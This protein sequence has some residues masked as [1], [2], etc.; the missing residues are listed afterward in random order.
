M[1]EASAAKAAGDSKRQKELGRSIRETKAKMADLVKKGGFDAALIT[2]EHAISAVSVTET[3]AVAP[4]A[5]G[6]DV[7]SD[8]VS[9]S[10]KIHDEFN[11]Q[12][13]PKLSCSSTGGP[14][15]DEDG[16]EVDI[17]DYNNDGSES[18]GDKA[19]SEC[20]VSDLDDCEYSTHD[21]PHN[22]TSKGWTGLSPRDLLAEVVRRKF[23]Y[24]TTS[25]FLRTPNRCALSGL[26]AIFTPSNYTHT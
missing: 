5:T 6:T 7:T 1:R 9:V 25:A 26:Y 14:P 24:G 23:P 10:S 4:D 11:W 20:G 16:C 3:S 18:D 21:W 17:F 22:F 13:V 19:K 2:A 15:S 12:G 8:D